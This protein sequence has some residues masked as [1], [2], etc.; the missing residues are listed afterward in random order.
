MPDLPTTIELEVVVVL[1]DQLRFTEWLLDSP[2]LRWRRL[3]IRGSVVVLTP[4][5]SVALGAGVAWLVDGAPAGPTLSGLLS[6]PDFL[7]IMAIVSGALALFYAVLG[8]IRRPLLRRRLRRLLVE[9]PGIDPADPA[10]SEAARFTFGTDGFT[11]RTT[12][13]TVNIGWAAV[14]GLDDAGPILVLKTGR[15]TG[16][17]I[18]KRCLSAAQLATL[19]ETVRAGVAGVGHAECRRAPRDGTHSQQRDAPV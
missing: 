19:D 9:R 18:P 6:D 1:D 8:S 15:W 5:V 11:S 10:L 14:K 3:L 12:A 2:A 7:V 16:Y 17:I 13:V 4:L